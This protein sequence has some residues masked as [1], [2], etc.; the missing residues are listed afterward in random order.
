VHSRDPS[1][2]LLP[3]PSGGTE[4]LIGGVIFS[5]LRFLTLRVA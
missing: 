1:V 2:R 4:S 5:V 3:M